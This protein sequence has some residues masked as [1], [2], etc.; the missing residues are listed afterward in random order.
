MRELEKEVRTLQDTKAIAQ[1][2]IA[3]QAERCHGLQDTVEW[4]ISIYC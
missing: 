1:E 4:L 3:T 2:M